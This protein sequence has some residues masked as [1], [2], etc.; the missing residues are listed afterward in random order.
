[1]AAHSQ[2]LLGIEPRMY[3]HFVVA[4][5]LISA[6]LAIVL[7]GNDRDSVLA[8]MQVAKQQA[9]RNRAQKVHGSKAKL[10]DNRRG[11]GDARTNDGYLGGQYGAPMENVGDSG[12]SE[13]PFAQMIPVQTSAAI[14][15]AILKKMTPAQRAAYLKQ[16]QGPY[17]PSPQ[18]ISTLT[19]ASAQ[20]SGVEQD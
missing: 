19:A 5:L 11:T 6:V 2:P 7:D 1:M 3:R 4:T 14:D 15:P 13:I 9:D 18:E 8:E 16:A 17:R 10:V 12:S 20:R